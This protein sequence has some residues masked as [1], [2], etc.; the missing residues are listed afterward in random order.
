VIS[1]IVLA[2]GRATR[3][4][5]CKQLERIGQNTILDHVLQNLRASNVDDV[6]VVLGAY[7]DEIRE[8]VH[9]GER[10]ITN[11][12]YADGMS[13]SIHAG[14]R[15]LPEGTDAALIVLGDQPFVTPRTINRLIDEYR[16]N[17]AR[18]IIPTYKGVRGNPVLIDR[19]LFPEMMRIRGDVGCKSVLGDH[20][21]NIVQLAVEDRGVLID[22]DRREDLETQRYVY[23]A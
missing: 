23:G 13:S 17:P 6:V 22:I 8:K 12:D 11:S 4:G 1:A 15:A 3:F 2:A 21:K 20:G 16:R 5:R 7:A 14:L 18:A 19:S 10:V 9:M